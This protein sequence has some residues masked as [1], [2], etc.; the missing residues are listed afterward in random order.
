MPAK[1][2]STV[3]A[4]E[5]R[6]TDGTLLS[7]LGKGL[8]F[9]TNGDFCPDCNHRGYHIHKT[10]VE[11]KCVC[12]EEGMRPMEAK[13][14]DCKETGRFL[15]KN[16][17]KVPCRNC[18]ETGIYMHPTKKVR[19]W[20][21]HGERSTLSK[22]PQVFYI[23]CGTCDGAGEVPIANPALPKSAVLALVLAS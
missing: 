15:Q 6:T 4:R 19:C 5:P 9:D 12:D 18:K 20:E 10:R 2:N 17:I 3:T 21:C 1:N 13:C 22:E 16:G 11:E 23:K 7:K 8:D 14:R